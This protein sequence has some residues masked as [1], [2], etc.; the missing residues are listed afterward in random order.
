MVKT[1]QIPVQTKQIEGLDP[2]PIERSDMVK[3]TNLNSL[4]LINESKFI[5][6]Q[7]EKYMKEVI[8]RYLLIVKEQKLLSHQ[9]YSGLLDLDDNA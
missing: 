8:K 2:S 1:K 7:R 6:K 5:K 3:T 4:L 9:Q